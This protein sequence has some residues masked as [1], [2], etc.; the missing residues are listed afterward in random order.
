MR[1]AEISIK[2]GDR[3][4]GLSIPVFNVNILKANRK[5]K[6]PANY[7]Q[8]DLKMT[9]QEQQWKPGEMEYYL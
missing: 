2:G 6:L 4:R 5:D 9:F 8:L 1:L 3:R 7:Q